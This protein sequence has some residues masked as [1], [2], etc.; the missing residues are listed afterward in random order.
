MGQWRIG[1]GSN[2]VPRVEIVGVRE[3]SNNLAIYI[4]VEKKM[5]KKVE[6]I[7]EKKSGKKL[8]SLQTSVGGGRNE[9]VTNEPQRNGRLRGG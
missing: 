4:K 2:R 7:I 6:K 3:E 5:G 8:A 9:C 1:C